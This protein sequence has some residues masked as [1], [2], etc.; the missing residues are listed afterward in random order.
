MSATPAAFIL[1]VSPAITHIK[2]N[3]RHP[4]TPG[5]SQ[6]LFK[7]LHV[8]LETRLLLVGL[9]M[10][11]SERSDFAAIDTV[12]KT[13]YDD[14][15]RNPVTQG[16]KADATY[17]D[18]KLATEAV[19][20]AGALV[21]QRPANR[22]IGAEESQAD[23]K[24]LPEDTCQQICDALFSNIIQ[25]ITESFQSRTTNSDE[26]I[27]ETA[28]ALQRAIQS[29]SQGY[30][31]LVEQAMTVVRS[32]KTQGL[33]A[34]PAIQALGPLLGYI[35]CSELPRVPAEGLKNF[36]L[37]TCSLY[38]ELHAAINSKADI[39]IWCALL[40]SI[41]AASRNFNDACKPAELVNEHSAFID[42]WAAGISNKYPVLEKLGT[43]HITPDILDRQTLVKD[44][45]LSVSQ[46]RGDFLLI[47][48]FVV[49]SLYH[50]ATK[51]VNEHSITGGKALDLSEDFSG[52]NVASESQYL[53]LLA[54][55]AGF[56]L[57]EMTEDQQLAIGA[58]NYTLHLF[59][60]DFITTP[61]T[62][63]EPHSTESLES[64]AEK[65]SVWDWLTTG[66][67]SVLS[68]GILESLRPSGVSK[69]V[70]SV[71]PF[72]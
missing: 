1:M 53:H 49:Q 55:L 24:L 56:V 70:R 62:M 60:S 57:V 36:L 47:A 35:G 31:S 41:Q 29:F 33:D 37:L 18:I 26:L 5:H 25:S 10:S 30:S 50:K 44:V 7:V 42:Q 69:L 68:F 39:K 22:F 15:Y 59:Q 38:S 67:L 28:K 32:W 45:T 12:F 46:V 64:I 9:D 34:I 65:G 21:C 3:L 52:A 4:R 51:C 17:D 40:A 2:E 58:H 6:D 11:G 63:V 8:I 43:D 71:R 27:N 23:G 16:G 13:L 19:Q 14:V 48:L 61:T 54:T 20:G 66:R 72:S